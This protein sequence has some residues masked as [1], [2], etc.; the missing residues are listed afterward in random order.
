MKEFVVQN[1]HRTRHFVTWKPRGKPRSGEAYSQSFR[2]L[3]PG[4]AQR[5]N[6]ERKNRGEVRREKLNDCKRLP[7]H[8]P[9]LL[10]VRKMDT[11]ST[12]KITIQW[13]S[14]NEINRAIHW[15]A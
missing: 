14:V 11:L 6:G 15:I 9:Q 3:H 7:D 13:I 10:V 4:A 8:R 5:E 1:H 2:Y 12:G